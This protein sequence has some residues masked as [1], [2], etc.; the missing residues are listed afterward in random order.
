MALCLTSCNV[1]CIYSSSLS[2]QAVCSKFRLIPRFYWGILANAVALGVSI[3]CYYKF[4]EVMDDFMGL[5]SYFTS[6]YFGIFLS[7][8]H[9]YRPRRGYDLNSYII[10]PML[11]VGYASFFAFCCGVAGG[12]V[13]MSEAWWTG[14]LAKAISQES[15]GDIGFHLS[16][17]FAFIG[18]AS[19]RWLELKYIGR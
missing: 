6:L 11:P 13:G 16:F 15:P 2:A 17:T 9:L 8:H 5:L 12:A 1:A 4:E 7:E 14:P 10:P 19:T 3:S 18:H